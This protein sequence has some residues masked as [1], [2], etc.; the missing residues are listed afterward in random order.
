ML[1]H[2]ISFFITSLE[3]TEKSYSP[4]FWNL[5]VYALRFYVFFGQ[6]LKTDKI[7]KKLFVLLAAK[8]NILKLCYLLAEVVV[9]RCSVKQVFLKVTK[10]SQENTC[11]TASFL[12]QSL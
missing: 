12:T 6:P 2:M 7:S 3:Y 11:M 5:L 4:V 8:T 10:N 9:R 1:N